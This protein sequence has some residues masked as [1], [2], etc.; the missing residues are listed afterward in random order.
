MV[1]SAVVVLIIVEEDLDGHLSLPGMD[2][3]GDD[4][5]DWFL[6][7]FPG[8]VQLKCGDEDLFPGAPQEDRDSPLDVVLPE[9]GRELHFFPFKILP[10]YTPSRVLCLFCG[11]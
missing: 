10:G 4:C 1:G 7:M 5:V 2:E 6:A 3:I 11:R 9:Y 8:D